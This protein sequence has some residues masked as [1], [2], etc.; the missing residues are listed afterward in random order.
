MSA[1]IAA[2]LAD[3]DGTLVTKDKVLTDRAVAAVHALQHRGV[4]FAVTSGRPPGG[5]T[6]LVEP[7]GMTVPMAAF[8][9]GA[10][11]MPD[12]RVADEAR[13]PAAHAPAIIDTIRRHGLDAWV[14]DA[15]AWYLTDSRAPHAE[16]EARTVRCAPQVVSDFT[17]V[18]DRAVKIVGVSDDAALVQRCEAAVHAQFGSHVNAIRS[19]P[20]Y[21]D[22]THPSATKGVVVQRLSRYA[23]IAAQQIA[24]IG[25]QANDVPMFLHSGMSIAMG[26]APD[27]VRR[28]AT[29]ITASHQDE[30]FAKAVER[31]VLPAA[32]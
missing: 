30:G 13:I 14:F 22:V 21:L 6:Q 31:Y 24:T 8:N 23:G 11:V 3:V 32:A 29:H 26:N 17:H 18:L 12:M 16:R 7:L 28:H 9:G 20:Y 5:L 10:I 2:L 15:T 25:D 27:D 4:L 1:A 19:Q